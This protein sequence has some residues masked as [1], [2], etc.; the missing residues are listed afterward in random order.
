LLACVAIS[1]VL[2]AL[3]VSPPRLATW[4]LEQPP[5]LDRTHFI[6]LYLWHV[7]I[8]HGAL[9][10]G[11]VTRLGIGV[12]PPVPQVRGNL[13][14]GHRVLLSDRAADAAS[15]GA[16]S[17]SPAAVPWALR[18][19]ARLSRP[20]QQDPGPFVAVAEIPVPSQALRPQASAP[21]GQDSGRAGARR[22]RPAVGSGTA[23]PID[24]APH[25]LIGEA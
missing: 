18:S 8:F 11:R 17:G 2:V 22:T 9:N 6:R 12:S 15:E 10:S 13:R 1:V 19:P 4:V 21:R 7:P 14:R 16:I 3:L 24:V 5:R 23:R 25:R 20:C